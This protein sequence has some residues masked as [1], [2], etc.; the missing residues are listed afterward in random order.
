MTLKIFGLGVKNGIYP[1][2]LLLTWKYVRT[3]NKTGSLDTVQHKTGRYYDVT[4]KIE[5][6][7]HAW[8]KR[9][10][11]Q[12]I[13]EFLTHSDLVFP[14][15]LNTVDHSMYRA[16]R[17]VFTQIFGDSLGKDFHANSVHK[18]WDPQFHKNKENLGS[19]VFTSHLEQTGHTEMT[20]LRN[21]VVPGDKRNTLNIYL[22][23]LSNI[24][25][26][27][28]ESNPH[29]C[30]TAA[31]PA[32]N[33]PIKKK[34]TTPLVTTDKLAV[35]EKVTPHAEVELQVPN[36]TET[37]CVKS[38]RTKYSTT[39]TPKPGLKRGRNSENGTPNTPIAATDEAIDNPLLKA[40]PKRQK[41]RQLRKVFYM[42]SEEPESD[43]NWEVQEVEYKPNESE[44]SSEEDMKEV[45]AK[46]GEDNKR[47]KQF[48]NSLKSSRKHKPSPEEQRCLAVFYYLKEPIRKIQLIATNKK[49]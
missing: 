7:R 8:L 9:L 20:A 6:D 1:F 24:D 13:R 15:A 42:D 5:N 38:D 31:T 23:T 29:L 10:R 33:H 30:S 17:S 35:L 36:R 25:R 39:E 43:G 34:T 27:T 14:T 41:H 28:P 16:I 37:P 4:I 46:K 47:R 45:P 48:I 12:Y 32:G 11:K 22:N 21:Y 49:S 19:A 2:S 26:S 44:D 3:I 18:M 40:R